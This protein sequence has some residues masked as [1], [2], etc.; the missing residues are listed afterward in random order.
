MKKTLFALALLATFL[1]SCEN[2]TTEKNPEAVASMPAQPTIDTLCFEF[3]FK[4][5]ITSC[6]LIIDGD[7]VSG[8]FD[9]SP[10]EKDGGHGILKNGVKKGDMITVDWQMMIE[11]SV[12]TEELLFKLE[13]DK[14]SQLEGELIEKGDKI[15]IKSPETAKVRDVLMKVDCIKIAKGIENAKSA[16]EIMNK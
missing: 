1:M 2:T 10:F 8:C 7:K 14:L 6:Q 11:G 12:Q 15:V 9:W 13:D 3:K 5:D 4:N 16:A